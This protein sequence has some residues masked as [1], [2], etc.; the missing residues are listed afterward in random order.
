MKETIR[1]TSSEALRDQYKEILTS[2]WKK[3]TV[4]EVMRLLGKEIAGT[5][6]RSQMPFLGS[7]IP[8]RG[9]K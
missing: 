7:L 9:N 2:K 6:D 4:N 8:N 5:S 3:S 1:I